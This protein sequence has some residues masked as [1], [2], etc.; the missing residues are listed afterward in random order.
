M[1][2][3]GIGKRITE[4]S[5]KWRLR[6]F[7]DK[8]RA[9]ESDI[10]QSRIPIHPRRPESEQALLLSK[11]DPANVACLTDAGFDIVSLANNHT[12]DCGPR[13]PH[14]HD[15]NLDA[16]SVCLCGCGPT[17]A[18]RPRA[19][20]HPVNGCGVA[21]LARDVLPEIVGYRTDAPTTR[22]P[23]SRYD[24]DEIRAAAR[25]GTS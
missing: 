14:G 20:I 4:N 17:E 16:A 9:A 2:A 23:R 12:L 18:G 11:G 24:E 10:L 7:R 21:I 15:A 22:T 1:L 25:Q 13:W 3:R 8:L 5:T 19:R 6:T